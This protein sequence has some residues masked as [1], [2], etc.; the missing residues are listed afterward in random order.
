M[1]T[2]A[3][4]PII[5]LGWPGSGQTREKRAVQNGMELLLHHTSHTVSGLSAMPAQQQYVPSL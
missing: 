3:I 4:T 1:S 2:N 5:L